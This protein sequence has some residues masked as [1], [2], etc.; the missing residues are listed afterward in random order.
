MST[1]M[2]P[3]KR[4]DLVHSF[5]GSLMKLYSMSIHDLTNRIGG[6]IQNTCQALRY[7][8]AEQQQTRYS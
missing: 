6:C 2:E 1:E 4:R 5:E 3:E 8:T 7:N